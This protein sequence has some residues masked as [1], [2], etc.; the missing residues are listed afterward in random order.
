M[1]AAVD[2]IDDLPAS[3]P[4]FPL[5]GV[6][7]LPRGHLPLNIF[8]PR[9]RNMT[10][11]ALD[12]DRLIGM[13]QPVS[14]E[15]IPVTASGRIKNLD[16]ERLS[17]Y[18]TGCVGRIG[19]CQETPDGRYQFT[20]TGVCRFK[21]GAEI[22]TTRGYRRFEANW[23]GFEGDLTKEAGALNGRHKMLEALKIYFEANNLSAD[24]TVIEETEDEDLI[25]ALSML[26]PF[27]PAEKQALLEA[28]DLAA[29][30]EVLTA[31]AQMG[32]HDHSNEGLRPQ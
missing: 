8:E 7:L 22:D 27:S 26:S 12:A 31:I 11:D 23:S 21:L 18:T 24:W 13:I 16:D 9:Y 4:V 14:P 30:C 5:S 1:N 2:S 20:L 10:R 29:R 25:T 32:A 15:E 28:T 17:L 6:L 3:V 19:R